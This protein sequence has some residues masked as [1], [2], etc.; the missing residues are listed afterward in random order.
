MQ[1]CFGFTFQTQ[2]L[3]RLWHTVPN[4][5][6]TCDSPCVRRRA[7]HVNCCKYCV[8]VTWKV[9][10]CISSSATTGYHRL[11]FKLRLGIHVITGITVQIK[12]F[13][14][15]SASQ[16]CKHPSLS[17]CADT[18]PGRLHWRP[19][20]ISVIFILWEHKS[21]SHM[22]ILPLFFTVFSHLCSFNNL[23][24]KDS[25]LWNS[26][27]VKTLWTFFVLDELQKKVC[28]GFAL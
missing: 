20:F 8:H 19:H 23:S 12:L 14:K 7:L 4:L 3:I 27:Q 25:G 17:K 9:H 13:A 15:A 1:L 16:Q 10:I 5:E 24:H 28:D 11:T 26:V 18:C 6:L 2:R 22:F 21:V